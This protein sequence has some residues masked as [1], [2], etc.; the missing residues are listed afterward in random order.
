MSA[1]KLATVVGWDVFLPLSILFGPPLSRS[2]SDVWEVS[3]VF[4][5]PSVAC[6]C[7][8]AAAMDKLRAAGH[9]H[10]GVFRQAALGVALILLVL[11]EIG[12]RLTAAMQGAPPVYHWLPWV[13]YIAYLFLMWTALRN[14]AQHV[15]A[16]P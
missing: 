9:D 4:L 14:G 1:A 13:F 2:V 6:L 15:P 7:R 3:W 10:P 16:N 5:L 11:D 12:S 8:G